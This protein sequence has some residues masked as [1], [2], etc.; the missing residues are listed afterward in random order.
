MLRGLLIDANVTQNLPNI[1][2]TREDERIE[3][4]IY[5]VVLVLK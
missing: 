3:Y 4:D 2:A 5:L 1:W